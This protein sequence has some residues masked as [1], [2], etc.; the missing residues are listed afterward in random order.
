MAE[1]DRQVDGNT[2]DRSSTGVLWRAP[3]LLRRRIRNTARHLDISQNTYLTASA[4]LGE[5]MIA[6]SPEGIPDNVRTLFVHMNEAVQRGQR[7]VMDGCHVDDW[8]TLREVLGV[9]RD[10]RLVRDV[11]ERTPSG[12]D[13]NVMVY[14]FGFTKEGIVVWQHVGPLVTLFLDAVVLMRK[15]Q[16]GTIAPA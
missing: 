14:G 10:A 11:V 7:L 13:K 8:T 4:I 2:D 3:S 16:L 12:I 1:A 15:P 9:L 6:R 5:L